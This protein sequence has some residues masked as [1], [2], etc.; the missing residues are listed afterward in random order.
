MCF[1]YELGPVP[2]VAVPVYQSGRAAGT[3][4]A[5]IVCLFAACP[6][7]LFPSGN[8]LRDDLQMIP[9]GHVLTRLQ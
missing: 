7:A 8:A 6:A 1:A 9:L 5:V 2:T 3:G 4:C